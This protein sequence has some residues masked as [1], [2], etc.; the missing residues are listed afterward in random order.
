MTTQGSQQLDQ[1][2]NETCGRSDAL[3]EEGMPRYDN[4]EDQ[5]LE[6]ERNLRK[7]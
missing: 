7:V 6:G 5:Q 4:S 1:K 3:G 2:V